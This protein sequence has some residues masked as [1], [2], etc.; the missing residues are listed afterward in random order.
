MRKSEKFRPLSKKISTLPS[1]AYV[2]FH[3]TQ[4]NCVTTS[5][6]NWIETTECYTWAMWPNCMKIIVNQFT[7]VKCNYAALLVLVL[8]VNYYLVSK[9]EHNEEK[10][11]WKRRKKGIKLCKH[12]N[13][14]N[15]QIETKA[16]LFEIRWRWR[17]LNEWMCGRCGLHIWSI[18]TN[19][20][21]RRDVYWCDFHTSTHTLIQ[22]AHIKSNFG[23]CYY[24]PN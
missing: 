22:K 5:V 15:L 24:K 13:R 17:L 3:F 1:H 11:K 16:K 4:N 12:K 21:H 7:W 18:C 14:L 19:G 23:F 10:P 20:M 9:Q 8:L 6:Y 2:S